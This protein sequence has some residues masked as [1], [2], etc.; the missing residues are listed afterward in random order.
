MALA[1]AGVQIEKEKDCEDKRAHH[2]VFQSVLDCSE[3]AFPHIQKESRWVLWVVFL[4][5]LLLAATQDFLG[6]K[7]RA[8]VELAVNFEQ[9]IK[10]NV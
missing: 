1:Q 8:S 5:A 7:G 4:D 3:V 2:C 6:Q 10:E 9:K